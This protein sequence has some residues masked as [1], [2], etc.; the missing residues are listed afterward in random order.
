MPSAD[1]C[2]T[3]PAPHGASS[4]DEQPCRSPRVLRTHFH[5]YACRIYVMAL[6][7]SIGL[8][9]LWTAYPAMLPRIRFLFV[10]PALC[11]GLPSDSQSPAKPLP[12]A[13]TS[14]CRVCGGLSPLSGCALPGA[15]QKSPHGRAS[16]D[17]W[18]AGANWRKI[19]LQSGREAR[20]S[21]ERA[22]GAKTAKP[23]AWPGFVGGSSHFL[24]GFPHAQSRAG[25]QGGAI[26]RI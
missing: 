11:L 18:A 26:G 21:W 5:A 2:T 6:R 20:D 22:V 13:S 8:C 3:V 19:S 7:A 10:R 4:P 15:P 1:F 12:L 17:G 23:G 24:A 14:P 25:R 9:R 16:G